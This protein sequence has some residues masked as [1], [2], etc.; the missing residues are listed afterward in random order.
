MAQLR[1]SDPEVL[2]TAVVDSVVVASDPDARR[3]GLFYWEMARPWTEAVVAAVRKAEDSEIRSLGER[4]AD[5]PGTPDHYHRLRAALVEQAALPSTAP[6]FDAAWEAECN[7]R[8]G[9]HL[10]GRHT[11]DAEPVS[12]EELRALPPGPAL[13]AGADPEVLIVVPF[14]DR[15]TGG[16]RLR[17]LLACLLALRDQ[18]FPRDRYQVTVV[19]SD[20][21][22]RWREVI[23]PFTDHYLFA[24][25]A[26]MFNKSW[27]V[28]AGVVNTPGRNEV[29]C[30]LDADVLADRDF[31]ARN[32]ERFRSP[33]VGG[34]MTYRKMSCLD[35]PTTAWAIRERV[36]RRGAEAGADQLRA[37]QLRRPPGCCLWVRTGTFHRIGGMDERYEGWGGEDNDFV[38]RFDIAAPF[39]NHDDWM[40]HMQHPPASLLRDDG[41]LV[42]AHIPPLSWQPEAPIGQLDRFASEPATEPTAGS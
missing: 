27:A 26:G 12:V 14:R 11:R 33:G 40:L 19:E 4:L 17:N 29:V 23:T 13:P 1:P 37:F 15:D 32:A 20:D 21:S 34:H 36:Q 35:G 38:Y 39:F 22:P 9:F 8:I 31:V 7:S 5:D 41:E 25:K 18:S 3:S 2:A 42:N 24:P 30:I 10:G 16:A 28:N 6:L